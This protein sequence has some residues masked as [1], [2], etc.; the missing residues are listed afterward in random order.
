[1]EITLLLIEQIVVLFLMM[2]CGYLLVK[3]GKAKTSDSHILSVLC[4]NLIT[5]LV[6][7]NAFQVDYS[8]EIRNGFLLALFAAVL[9]SIFLVITVEVLGRVF[10][11]NGVEKAS[12]GYSNAGN[13]IIPLVTS[14]L[15][16]EWVIYASAFMMVQLLFI[17]THGQSCLLE[18]TKFDLK[19][20]ITNLNIIS[21][22]VGVIL[23][24]FQIKLPGVVGTA[25]KNISGMIGPISMIM[26]GMIFAGTDLKKVFTNKKIYLVVFLKMIVTPTIIILAVKYSGMANWVS[27]GVTVLFISILATTT[28]S[29]TTITQLAQ[30]YNRQPDYAAAINIATTIV[31][32]V[33][34]PLMT[35]LYYL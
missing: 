6:I 8:D 27:N 12:L 23:F 9:I 32:L 1:M 34:M 10:K 20:I 16:P 28:P 11:L 7:I 26:L 15:G 3:A 13:L 19:K 30:L 33:T 29:A 18:E 14:I 2:G 21:I 5:P 24:V 31:C 35:M 4:V 22:F 25:V 17:W